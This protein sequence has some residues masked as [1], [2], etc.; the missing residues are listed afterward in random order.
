MKSN[1]RANGAY[2]IKT[3]IA[4]LLTSIYE[5]AF[6]VYHNERIAERIAVQTFWRKYRQYERAHNHFPDR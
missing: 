5:S 2:L 1:R 6:E 3:N 4:D